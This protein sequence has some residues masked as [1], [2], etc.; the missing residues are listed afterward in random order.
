M[1]NNC[2]FDPKLAIHKTSEAYRSPRIHA[3][4]MIS[5]QGQTV[6]SAFMRAVIG[7]LN[8]NYAPN[9]LIRA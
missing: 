5:V 6:T 3:P 7:T 1:V 2:S 9:S 8:T 4:E